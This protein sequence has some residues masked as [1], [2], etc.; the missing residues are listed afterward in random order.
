MAEREEK[1]TNFNNANQSYFLCFKESYEK[2]C[3][4]K[5]EKSYSL[6]T[7]AWTRFPAA[8]P[9]MGPKPNENDMLWKTD[10]SK[11]SKRRLRIK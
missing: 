1:H 9:A 2:I 11:V 10:D 8:T 4:K 7:V 5:E 6:E 3:L